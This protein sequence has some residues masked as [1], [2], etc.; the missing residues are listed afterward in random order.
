MVS[1][2][3]ATYNQEKYIYDAIESVLNQTFKHWEL[4]IINDASTDNTKEIINSFK[5]NDDRIRV[6]NLEQNKGKSFCRNYGF[7][8]S[9]GDLILYFDSDDIM[10]QN[11]IEILY[12]TIIKESVDIVFTDTQV[13]IDFDNFYQFGR[14]IESDKLP[15]GI[16]KHSELYK[17]IFEKNFITLHSAIV[18]R[19]AVAQIGGF[20]DNLNYLEDYDFWLRAIN[21]NYDFYYL[22]K[23]LTLYRN[24]NFLRD[25]SKESIMKKKSLEKIVLHSNYNEMFIDKTFL[26]ERIK[27]VDRRMI[28]EL[29]NQNYFFDALKNILEYFRENK[30]NLKEII[31]LISILYFLIIKYWKNVFIKPFD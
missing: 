30:Y 5:R 22:K 23:R 7:S 9:S 11:H 18:K 16:I 19:D 6:Y 1:V 21:K 2:I 12:D 15:Q 14:I 17:N 4:I 13:F 29:I 25:I 20:N 27:K 24:Y 31:R 10:R 8:Q 26:E 28:R 3:M